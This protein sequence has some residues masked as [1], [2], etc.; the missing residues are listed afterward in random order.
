[1]A[2]RHAIHVPS[3]VA[4]SR[5]DDLEAAVMTEA[6]PLDQDLATQIELIGCPT[7]GARIPQHEAHLHEHF[8]VADDRGQEPTLVDGAV[9]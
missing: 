8:R 6:E 4:D 1:M 3:L 2:A 9:R 7:C 5:Q